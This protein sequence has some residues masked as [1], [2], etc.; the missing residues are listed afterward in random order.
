[1]DEQKKLVCEQKKLVREQKSLMHQQKSLVREG[2]SWSAA[3]IGSEL[4]QA[5]AEV[6]LVRVAG[7]LAG[8]VGEL[9]HGQEV[10][11]AL[12]LDLEE[13]D[14]DV[15]GLHADV[16]G[17]EGADA[18]DVVQAAGHV[19]LDAGDGFEVEAVAVDH[20]LLF[21]PVRSCLQRSSM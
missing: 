11:F 17:E 21:R 18:V 7:V 9:D 15:E 12:G 10:R 1:M 19:A 5:L 3:R 8:G 20:G 16:V 4:Q 13:L 6:D 2:D 14:D